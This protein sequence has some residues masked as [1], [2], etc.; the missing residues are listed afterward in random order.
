MA[1]PLSSTISYSNLLSHR[2]FFFTVPPS[3]YFPTH[4]HYHK[5]WSLNQP[6]NRRFLALC[7]SYE[8]GGGFSPEELNMQDRTTRKQEQDNEKLDA[9][10]YEALFKGGEQV[11]SVLEE[12]IKLLE[13]MNMD[14]ASEEVAVQ[15]AAQGVIGK[16]VDQMESGFMMALDYMIQLAEK[17]QDHKEDGSGNS[18]C[19]L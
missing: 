5:Q 12:M 14:E 4:H 16:R 1:S 8:V 9:S 6:R 18:W 15:L 11:T 10:Q 13:D 3:S 19:N 7:A 17:D 2:F